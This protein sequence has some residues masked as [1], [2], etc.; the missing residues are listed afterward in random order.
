METKTYIWNDQ[1]GDYRIQSNDPVMLKEMKKLGFYRI[2]YD[3][4]SPLAICRATK[5]DVILAQQIA[6]KQGLVISYS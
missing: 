6:Q 2:G 3:L 1:K 5:S 4:C